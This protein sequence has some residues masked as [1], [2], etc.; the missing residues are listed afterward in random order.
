MAYL[1]ISSSLN[2]KSLSRLLALTAFNTFKKKGSSAE[3]LD[4]AD[5]SIP[6]CDGDSTH[7]NSEVK[8]LRE[9]TGVGFMALCDSESSL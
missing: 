5:H 8:K 9:I 4:L 2:P 6:F 1:I 7:K 3:W